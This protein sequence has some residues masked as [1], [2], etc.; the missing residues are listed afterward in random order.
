MRAGRPKNRTRPRTCLCEAAGRQTAACGVGRAAVGVRPT[1]LGHRLMSRPAHSEGGTGVRGLGQRADA[2]RC[3]GSAGPLSGATGATG[4]GA[5]W[6]L[7]RTGRIRRTGRTRRTG[8][9]AATPDHNTA[10]APLQAAV[11][12]PKFGSWTSRIAI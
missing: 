8:R 3:A 5:V 12:P 2:W 7:P 9:L 10:L 4:G 6:R 1:G 11:P